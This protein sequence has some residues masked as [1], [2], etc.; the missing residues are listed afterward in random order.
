MAVKGWEE[1]EVPALLH[2]RMV[3]PGVSTN[4]PVMVI[5]SLVLKC[6]CPERQ[7]ALC[8]NRRRLEVTGRV[9]VARSIQAATA[10]TSQGRNS[11]SAEGTQ[12]NTSP[13]S[14]FPRSFIPSLHSSIL[15]RN[16]RI[17]TTMSATPSFQMTHFSFLVLPSTSSSGPNTMRS[18]HLYFAAA[19]L[20]LCRPPVLPQRSPP[21]EPGSFK[22][23]NPQETFL[24]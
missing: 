8:G 16:T 23:R 11:M 13:S 6:S 4:R 15:T 22:G 3:V 5:G 12:H 1:C 14:S 20:S 9:V 10:G 24:W 19:Q 18:L 17:N 7:R 2:L 21:V